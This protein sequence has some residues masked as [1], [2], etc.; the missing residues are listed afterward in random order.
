VSSEKIETDDDKWVL[1]NGRRYKYA[2]SRLNEETV[3]ELEEIR[4]FMCSNTEL[5]RL[6]ESPGRP[7]AI[8]WAIGIAKD[9]VRSLRAR[10]ELAAKMQGQSEGG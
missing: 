1:V 5:R 10:A 8:R 7:D 3:A 2:H 6:V 4:S 9:H